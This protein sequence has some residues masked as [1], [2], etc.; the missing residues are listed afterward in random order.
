MIKRLAILAL[1]FG[2]LPQIGWAAP[3]SRINLT[4][5]L[6]S[7]CAINLSSNPAARCQYCGTAD[8][9][10]PAAGGMKSVTA[11]SSSKNTI[12]AKDL[13]NAPSDP[14]DRYVWATKLCLGIVKNCTAD[15]V[16]EAYDPL[17]E[18]SCTAA[19]ISNDMA[20]LQKKAAKN[21]KNANSCTDE[22]SICI[23]KAE[24]CNSDFSKCADDAKFNSFF[25]TCSS[26][27][28]GC[29]NFID[30]ARETIAATRKSTL[31]TTNSNIYAI[32]ASHRQERMQKL[33]S[34]SAGCKQN[35]AF[36]DC[37]TSACLNNTSNNCATQA[38]QTIANNLCQFYKTACT[39]VSVISNKDS[40]KNLDELIEDIRKELNM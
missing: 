24:K 1:G 13:K 18:K 19:G 26:Q 5:C 36:D 20:S 15:D 4:K 8:A 3:C 31:S 34:I 10:E 17:I 21:T 27:A 40:D 39:K 30:K 23:T 14:G 33:T 22:I 16:S 25:A 6:D 9:G 28:T 38:E 11:G 2:V 7:A 37:V 35:A 32:A 29:T 12:S